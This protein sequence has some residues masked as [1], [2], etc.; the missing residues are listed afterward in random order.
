LPRVDWNTT[1]MR[2]ANKQVKGRN[3]KKTRGEDVR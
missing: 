1:N 3:K 2:K